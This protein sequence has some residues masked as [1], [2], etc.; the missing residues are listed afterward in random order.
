MSIKQFL[1]AE[2]DQ[3]TLVDSN[4]TTHFEEMMK[5]M[6]KLE[7]EVKLLKSELAKVLIKILIIIVILINHWPLQVHV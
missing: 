1:L 4:R 5:R 2:K 7:E 6:E 3:L